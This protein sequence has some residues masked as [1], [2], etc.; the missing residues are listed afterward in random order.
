MLGKPR[1]PAGGFKSCESDIS[2]W[3]QKAEAAIQFITK[4]AR[5]KPGTYPDIG[6]PP[7]MAKISLCPGATNSLSIDKARLW[8]EQQTSNADQLF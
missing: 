8:V 2:F 7:L 3:G 4:E 1:T 6:E 5:A